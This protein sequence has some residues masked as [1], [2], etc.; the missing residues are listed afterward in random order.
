MCFFCLL[1]FCF[2]SNSSDLRLTYDTIT[3]NKFPKIQFTGI[4][5]W[6]PPD[7]SHHSLMSKKSCHPKYR[8]YGVISLSSS[9]TIVMLLTEKEEKEKKL[10][11]CL[12]HH[13]VIKL[14]THTVILVWA[15][16]DPSH[17]SFKP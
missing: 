8:L 3:V 17:Y 2:L 5:V 10:T 7:L 12:T 4:S 1:S 9:G 13:I 14:A 11:N 15:P 6:G 16:S